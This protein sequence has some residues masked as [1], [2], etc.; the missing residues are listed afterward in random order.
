MKLLSILERQDKRTLM[1]LGIVL[2]T[3]MMAGDLLTGPEFESSIFYLIPVSFFAWLINRRIGLVTALASAIS[4]LVIHAHFS[5]RSAIVY[6]N[7]GAWLGVYVFFVF[8]L[9]ELRELYERERRFSRTDALTKI[10]N[11]RAF[12]E[13]LETE[14]SRARRYQSP[15]TLAYIDLDHFKQ[16]NDRLGHDAGDRL[17]TVVAETM[18]QHLRQ[19]DIAA[20]LGGDEFAVLLPETGP[21]SALAVLRK[22]HALLDSAMRQSNWSVTFSLGAVSFHP[23]PQS[24]EEMVSEAD[25]AMYVAKS[26]GKDRLIVRE[27]AA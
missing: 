26:S 21:A 24:L 18:A 10:F 11:R 13:A 8:M 7:A 5:N 9:A 6:L 15:L 22:L 1:A 27:S 3:A 12:F 2:L 19:N 20:R 25:K 4:T 17:L 16:I 14:A 23:P